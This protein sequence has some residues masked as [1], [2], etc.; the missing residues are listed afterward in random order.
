[1]LQRKVEQC[2]RGRRER[3]AGAAS[4]AKLGH[5]W[6]SFVV[7]KNF[8]PTRDHRD[9]RR[10]GDAH[11]GGATWEKWF[12]GRGYAVFYKSTQ[13]NI[14]EISVFLYHF[15]CILYHLRNLAKNLSWRHGFD[16]FLLVPKKMKRAMPRL[17]W[18]GSGSLASQRDDKVSE[19]DILAFARRSAGR[20][21][22]TRPPAARKEPTSG[23]MARHR[24]AKAAA[25]KREWRKNKAKEEAEK[26]AFRRRFDRGAIATAVSVPRGWVC[27]ASLPPASFPC[28]IGRRCLVLPSG[29]R[30]QKPEAGTIVRFRKRTGRFKG[31]TYV[32]VSIGSESRISDTVAVFCPRPPPPS[33]WLAQAQAKVLAHRFA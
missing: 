31:N 18:V 12:V 27:V 30:R 25:A 29:K 24:R 10:R 9:P 21:H 15:P 14:R 32:Y 28:L 11:F 7:V 13:H 1:M 4:D 22:L 8:H 16:V 17:P 20:P 6:A 19:D 33:T 5:E 2:G 23:G 26:H 3:A